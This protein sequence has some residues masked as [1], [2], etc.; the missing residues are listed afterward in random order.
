MNDFSEE[1]SLL[2]QRLGEAEKYLKI[3][4]LRDQK[5]SLEQESADPEL[6]NCLLYTS[7]AADE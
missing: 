2:R 6:W 1:I 5:L 4:E 3:D 7:D